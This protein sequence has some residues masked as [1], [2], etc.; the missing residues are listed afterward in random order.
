MLNYQD[1]VFTV[2]EAPFNIISIQIE[3][4]LIKFDDNE[5]LARVS[6]RSDEILT[7][8]NQKEKNSNVDALWRPEY[9]SF[10]LES[11][12]G[13]PYEGL[14][15]DIN[16][17]EMNMRRRRREALEQL[18]KNEFIMTLTSFPRLGTLDFTWPIAES[19]CNHKT[20]VGRSIFFPDEAISQTYPRFMSFTHNVRQRRGENVRIKLNVFK[21]LHTKI[22][23]KG[24]P[25]DQ[26]DA[27]YMD[28]IG[29]GAGCCCLQVTFQA[30]NVNEARVLYDQ[31][32]PICPLMLALTAGAPAFRGYLVDSDSRWDVLSASMDCRTREERGEVPLKNGQFKIP[33]SRY[34]SLDSYLTD[35]G[36]K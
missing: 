4:I 10:M 33:K 24:A 13:R 32:A 17:V 31:L 20:S 8:L 5:K 23:V 28:A 26:P 11:S 14:L 21:D 12:P 9:G 29:F 2:I 35:D 36:E 34:S 22:P 27:V 30:Q 7:T 19:Q 25:A 3:H 1:L 18:S 6:L 16:S 15:K